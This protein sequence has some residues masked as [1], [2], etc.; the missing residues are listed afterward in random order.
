MKE[1]PKSSVA[2]ALASTETGWKRSEIV[3][4]SVAGRLASKATMFSSVTTV[5]VNT[6]GGSLSEGSTA[7]TA[8]TTAAAFV[9][10]TWFSL[11]KKTNKNSN[12]NKVEKS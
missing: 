2:R 5:H 12:N 4:S 10:R 7:T 9:A 11:K 8:T 3:G 1:S 6:S